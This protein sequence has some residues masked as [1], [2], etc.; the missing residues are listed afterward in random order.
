MWYLQTNDRRLDFWLSSPFLFFLIINM[1]VCKIYQTWIF[2]QP[3]KK[4]LAV[5]FC[6]SSGTVK[7]RCGLG[8]DVLRKIHGFRSVSSTWCKRVNFL[9]PPPISWWKSCEC[10]C[11]GYLQVSTRDS[12]LRRF[13]GIRFIKVPPCGHFW[14]SGCH[15]W[16]YYGSKYWLKPGLFWRRG[17]FGPNLQPWELFSAGGR[18]W[19]FSPQIWEKQSWK[20]QVYSLGFPLPKM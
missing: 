10:A 15:R 19:V 12:G 6:S 14:E 4:P 17:F 9:K 3:Q 8:E 2:C 18:Y 16:Y 1:F 20:I 5:V 7:T 13:F 11:H